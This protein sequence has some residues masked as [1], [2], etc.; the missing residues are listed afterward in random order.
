MSSLLLRE[1]DKCGAI[2]EKI[3]EF[4]AK[5]SSCSI[6]LRPVELNQNSSQSY[7]EKST[8]GKVKSSLKSG[9]SHKTLLTVASVNWKEDERSDF[10]DSNRL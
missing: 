1:Q 7:Q 3:E 4:W 5:D 9:A 6:V 2:C 8:T 10:T